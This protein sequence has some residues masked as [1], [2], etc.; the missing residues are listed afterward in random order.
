V[1]VGGGFTGL[2]AALHL[3]EAGVDTV[4]LE[5]GEP[6]WGA[7]GRNGG[8]VITGLKQSASELERTFGSGRGR[9]VF[10]FAE[11]AA[12]F[13]FA[14]VGRHGIECEAARTGWIRAVHSHAAL[15]AI[16]PAVEEMRRRGAPLEMLDRERVEELLGTD[17]YVGGFLDPRG[18]RLQPMSYARG[19][20]RAAQRQG[21]RIHG[22]CRVHRLMAEGDRWRVE[23]EGGSVTASR[24]LLATN[25]YTDRLWPRLAEGVIPVYSV[26][27]ATRPLGSNLRRT[28]L[29]DGHVVSDSRRLLLYFRLDDEGRLVFGGR[30][31][32]RDGDSSA[33]S[34][35]V[36][37]AMR[38]VFPALAEEGI[39]FAWS[40]QVALTLDGLPHVF[41]LAPGVVAA[42][43]Y[44]GRGVAMATTLGAAVAEAFCRGEMDELALPATALR[45]I[46]FHAARLPILAL[47]TQFYRLRDRLGI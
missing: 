21:G 29:R 35:I 45:T 11:G 6:G 34:G 43:G 31:S 20:A 12:D 13:L 9:R 30:G 8:Q 5:T 37:T 24:V 25:A 44:N 26:Q 19:L 47:A 7:S 14:L 46:P 33:S 38:R 2:S 16:A 22:S 28:I 4:L 32:L 41:R 10:D 42:L 39:E 17:A 1:I 15:G 40:G 18:G 27:V 3:A 36:T 23:T